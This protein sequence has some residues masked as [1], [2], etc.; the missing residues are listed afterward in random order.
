M[1]ARV[2]ISALLLG[3]VLLASAVEAEKPKVLVLFESVAY[4]STYSQYL[5]QIWQQGYEVE[6]RSATDPDLHLREWDDWKYE[7]LII[8][9]SGIKGANICWRSCLLKHLMLFLLYFIIACD[10]PKLSNAYAFAAK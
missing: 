6:Q 1:V 4:A 2:R 3:A 5:D 9:A 7:K 8:F 10:A